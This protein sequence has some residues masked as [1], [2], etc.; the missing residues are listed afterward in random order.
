[1]G[2]QFV[3]GLVGAA[4]LIY[5]FRYLL[6]AFGFG[7]AANEAGLMELWHKLVDSVKEWVVSE[8]ARQGGLMLDRE[9][10]LSD[11]SLSHA[12]SERTGVNLRTVKDKVMVEEDL[13]AWALVMVEKKTGGLRLSNIKD[14]NATKMDVLRF[15]GARVSEYA[16]VPLSDITDKEK[17]R[18]ELKE[19]AL[20][21]AYSHMGEDVSKAM[22]MYAQSGV[23]MGAVIEQ[24]N[25]MVKQGGSEPL[26]GK[27]I[28]M[29]MLHNG[30]VQQIARIGARA[31]L[32]AMKTRRQLQM[33]AASIR[34]REKHG[35]RM[36][37]E[38]LGNRGHFDP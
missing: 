2:I 35:S 33:Q 18:E 30:M 29:A 26:D 25:S 19:W 1:M 36:K 16:G 22:A 24:V 21:Q 6:T 17:T 11:A 32:T 20:S 37:Y 8:A 27:K 7:A 38:P 10:P 15:A 23:N 34:F 12:I 13:T 9:D 28:V 4:A 5:R 31:A 14:A 3:A